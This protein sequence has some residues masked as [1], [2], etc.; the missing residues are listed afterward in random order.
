MSVLSI[1][2]GKYCIVF[3]ILETKISTNVDKM[4]H[5]RKQRFRAT[6]QCVSVAVP[7]TNAHNFASIGQYPLTSWHENGW[8]KSCSGEWRRRL[9]LSYETRVSYIINAELVHSH[10]PDCTSRNSRSCCSCKQLWRIL[11]LAPQARLS[12][13]R[14]SPKSDSHRNSARIVVSIVVVAM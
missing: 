9:P 2:L 13:A 14:V 12:P 5:L 7:Q 11:K 3:F 10:F 1:L 4:Q 6:S 8:C